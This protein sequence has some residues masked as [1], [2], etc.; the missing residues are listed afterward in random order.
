MALGDDAADIGQHSL[1]LEIRDPLLGLFE[2][3]DELADP[4]GELLGLR[5]SASLSS[6][7]SDRSGER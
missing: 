3:R 6:S 1:A 7:T 2:L 5:L 4:V